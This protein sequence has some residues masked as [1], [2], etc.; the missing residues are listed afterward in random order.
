MCARK[1]IRKQSG[2][3]R[4]I[5]VIILNYSAPD[6]LISKKKSRAGIIKFCVRIFYSIYFHLQIA[7]GGICLSVRLLTTLGTG[8]LVCIIIGVKIK[9][10][11]ETLSDLGPYPSGG[12]VGMINYANT[13]SHCIDA[14]F[15]FGVQW[16]PKFYQYLPYIL[17]LET[18]LLIVVEKSSF[19]IPKIAQRVERFYKV[20]SFDVKFIKMW[21]I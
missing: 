10:S 15:D 1:F 7:L 2:K 11:N 14:V 3:I 5:Y 16:I 21:L 19:K 20:S 4:N 6:F 13:D 12:S 9:G 8:D 17:L 18:L